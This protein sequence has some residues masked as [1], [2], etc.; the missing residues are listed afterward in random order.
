MKR[1]KYSIIKYMPDP[2]RGE[3]IN[4]GLVVFLQQKLDVRVINASAKLRML[5][6]SSSMD[7]I[8][9]LKNSIEEISQLAGSPER[10][11]SILRGFRGSS[12]L[13]DTAE[14]VIDDSNQYEQ[15]VRNLFNLLIKPYSTKEKTVRTPR[16]LS[17]LK[18]KFESMNILAKNT[19]ELSKHKVVYNYPLNEKSGFH[20]DFILKNGKFHITEAIDFNVNDLNSKLKETSMKVMTFMEGRKALGDKTGSYFVYTATSTIEKE[21]TSHLNMASDYSDELFNLADTKD[22]ARYFDMMSSLAGHNRLIH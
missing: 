12:Y 2:K 10:A 15:R 18:D 20:A 1:F 19:D 21:I 3:I 14:F 7:D 5:D 17:H 9:H 4:V 11:M 16:I 13:S 6:G 22:A 8:E